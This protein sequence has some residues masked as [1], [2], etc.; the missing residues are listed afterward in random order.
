MSGEKA[1]LIEELK[2]ARDKLVVLREQWLDAQQEGREFLN[3]W[4]KLKRDVA[5]LAA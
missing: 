4:N 3:E 2:K 1:K 5:I